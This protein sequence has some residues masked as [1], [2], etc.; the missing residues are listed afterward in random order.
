MDRA[1]SK[2][3]PYCEFEGPLQILLE[4]QEYKHLL[5]SKEFAYGVLV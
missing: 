1:T 5:E 4:K 3:K 2:A